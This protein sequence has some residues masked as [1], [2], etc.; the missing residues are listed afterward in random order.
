MN[1][2]KKFATTRWSLV[3]A[4]GK[5]PTSDA[6]AALSRLCGLYWYP[7]YAFVRRSGSNADEAADLT[8]AFFAQ[9]LEK[10]DLSSADP[11]R[12]KFRSWLLACLRHFQVNQRVHANA[13][14]RGGGL[15]EL[16]IDATDAEGRYQVE[17]SHQLTAEKLYERRWTLALL[18]RAHEKLRAECAAEGERKLAVFT[19]LK[20]A[21]MGEADAPYAEVG[22]RLDM[23]EG[24]VKV[25]V[26]RLQKRHRALVRAEI[27]D[28]VKRPE[29]IAAELRELLASLE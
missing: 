29:D 5:A 17:P 8:Q 20:G 27:G 10:N 2:P 13:Q 23:S 24:A 6:R 14:K 18:D 15:S 16:S 26:H 22:L 9:L 1:A 7:L 12:G 19:A 28:T 11:N 25:A 21:L 3:L 4:A